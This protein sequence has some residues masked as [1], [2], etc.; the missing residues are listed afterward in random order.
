MG[1]AK[2]VPTKPSTLPEVGFGR[3]K[4]AAVAAT[5]LLARKKKATL[6]H[7]TAPKPPLTYQY[8]VGKGNNS[9]LI[10]QA[11]RKRPWFVPKNDSSKQR[12]FVWEMY[13]NRK[14]FEREKNRI[15]CNHLEHNTCLVNKDGLYRTMRAYCATE[16]REPMDQFMPL[17]FHVTNLEDAE[18]TSFKAAFTKHAQDEDKARATNLWILKPASM[19]NRGFGIRVANDLEEI[20]SIVSTEA[21]K[22]ARCGGWVC[23]KYIE[24]PL[25]IDGRKFDI[26]AFCLLVTDRKGRIQ[27]YAHRSCS[28][29]RTSSTKYSLKPQDL[30]KKGVHLVNDGVQNKEES[31]G[32]FEAGNKLALIDFAKRV[33]APANW[34]EET[35][36]PRMETI[37]KYTIDAAHARLNPKKRQACFELLGFDFMLDADLRVD[38][39]EINSNPCLETWSCPLLENLIPKLVDDVLRVGLDQI[40]PPPS[41][42]LTKRMAE[43]VEA[44]EAAGHDFTKI[45]GPSEEHVHFAE[46]PAEPASEPTQPTELPTGTDAGTDAGSGWVKKVDPDTGVAFFVKG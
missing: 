14:R 44:V 16:G 22:D 1:D 39:I 9:R 24:R 25:L 17:T 37:M 30:A 32:K 4:V 2:V 11:L 34:L 21:R 35:L 46:A 6:L 29:V 41:K 5:K 8:H 18:W 13:R 15:A 12:V 7:K 42:N 36:R 26:R 3:R 38:L 33:D 10:L 28:Y 27:A 45:F 43:A 40:L 20:E 19:S 23:Q 31:Y